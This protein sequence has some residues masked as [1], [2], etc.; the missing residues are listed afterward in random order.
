[1]LDS[2]RSEGCYRE[3]SHHERLDAKTNLRES[4]ITHIRE[5]GQGQKANFSG[6]HYHIVTLDYRPTPQG[7]ALKAKVRA[8]SPVWGLPGRGCRLT[9]G[10]ADC[11][12]AS[13]AQEAPAQVGAAMPIP[14]PMRP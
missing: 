3:A 14:K 9:R 1:M 12:E 8:A 6:Q 10:C 13:R 5:T 7:Q 11:S 2:K 4:F